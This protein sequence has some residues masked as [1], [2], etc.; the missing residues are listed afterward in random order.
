MQMTHV[1]CS[2]VNDNKLKTFPHS[3]DTYFKS[4]LDVY[5]SGNTNQGL[6]ITEGVNKGRP[7]TPMTPIQAFIGPQVSM[8]N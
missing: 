5:H 3:L 6:S 1:E 7:S 8:F 4:I 2:A